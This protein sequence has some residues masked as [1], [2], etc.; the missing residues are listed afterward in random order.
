MNG[1]DW[2]TCTLQYQKILLLCVGKHRQK[3][4]A[5]VMDTW[6]QIQEIVYLPT[7]VTI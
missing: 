3:A 4:F 7:K 5:F 6:N 2:H 1:R